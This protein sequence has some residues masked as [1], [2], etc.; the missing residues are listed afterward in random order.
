MHFNAEHLKLKI[1]RRFGVADARKQKKDTDDNVLF[2]YALQLRGGAMPPIRGLPRYLLHFYS[3][4]DMF[5]DVV[6]SKI[7]TKSYVFIK[8]LIF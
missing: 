8:W 4:F 2:L 6:F 7:F 1:S 5:C 3:F